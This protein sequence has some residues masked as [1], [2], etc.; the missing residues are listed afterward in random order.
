MGLNKNYAWY[1]RDHIQVE[2]AIFPDPFKEFKIASQIGYDFLNF[3]EKNLKKNP[4]LN[5]KLQNI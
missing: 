3:L 1:I 4:I 2:I 5:F